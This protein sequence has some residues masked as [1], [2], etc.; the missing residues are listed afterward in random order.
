[1]GLIVAAILIANGQC[2]EIHEHRSKEMK[3]VLLICSEC[4]KLAFELEVIEDFAFVQSHEIPFK[5]FLTATVVPFKY[6]VMV[7]IQSGFC[8]AFISPADSLTLLSLCSLQSVTFKT[9]HGDIKV[10]SYGQSFDNSSSGN[11]E[12]YPYFLL[13]TD[14]SLL[15][16]CAQ[17]GRGALD[18]STP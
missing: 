3:L 14:R 8:S 10:E 18:H 16:S 2:L 6:T 11:A 17:D 1:M 7:R 13:L 15:R 9:T 12:V 4:L 5:L